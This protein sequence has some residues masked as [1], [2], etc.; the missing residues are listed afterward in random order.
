MTEVIELIQGD[1]SDVKL[2]RPDFPGLAAALDAN[3]LCQQGVTDCAGALVVAMAPVA[4]K[5]ADEYGKERFIV[6]VSPTDSATL[7]VP[8]GEPYQDYTWVIE[9][10]N[11]TTV[12]SYNK[13][14]HITLRVSNQGSP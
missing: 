3:W 6:A 7:A 2:V 4:V 9:L 14:H 12:P 11:T 5:T 1:T 10:S 8:A 13:E